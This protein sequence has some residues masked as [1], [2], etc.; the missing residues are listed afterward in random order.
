LR[1]EQLCIFT[2]LLAGDVGLECR[3]DIVVSNDLAI[4]HLAGLSTRVIPMQLGALQETEREEDVGWVM[5]GRYAENRHAAS[6]P[7]YVENKTKY[8]ALE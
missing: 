4:L 8:G 2:H 7:L 3:S 6:Y 1:I 5:S